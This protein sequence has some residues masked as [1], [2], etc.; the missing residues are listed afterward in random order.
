MKM[1]VLLFL[2]LSFHSSLLPFLSSFSPSLSSCCCWCF[3]FCLEFSVLIEFGQTHAQHSAQ[4]TRAQLDNNAGIESQSERAAGM[5]IRASACAYISV[6]IHVLCVLNFVYQ[7]RALAQHTPPTA[8][9]SYGGCGKMNKKRKKKKKRIQFGKDPFAKFLINLPE[10]YK[11]LMQS[12]GSQ[13]TYRIIYTNNN[14]TRIRIWLEEEERKRA[15]I[16]RWRWCWWCWW[17]C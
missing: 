8:P 1:C 2:S 14:I 16:D 6:D 17:R 9:T 11:V 12:S 15:K 13:V 5:E 3:C 7:T 10:S 4:H